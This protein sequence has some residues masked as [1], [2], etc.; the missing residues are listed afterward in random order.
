MNR[1]LLDYSN[2][3]ELEIRCKLNNPQIID[4]F[5]HYIKSNNIR[6]QERSLSIIKDNFLYQHQLNGMT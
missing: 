6:K 3:K 5:N 4:I 2:D 1:I